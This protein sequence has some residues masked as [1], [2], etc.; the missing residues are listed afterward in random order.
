MLTQEV[1][2]TFIHMRKNKD[3]LVYLLENISIKLE[4]YF[5]TE[6]LQVQNCDKVAN[7]EK[8]ILEIVSFWARY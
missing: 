2:I 4:K 1:E 5:V 6:I 7:Y 8:I 3:F